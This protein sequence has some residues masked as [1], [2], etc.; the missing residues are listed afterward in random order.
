MEPVAA[1]P[2]QTLSGLADRGFYEAFREGGLL[3]WTNGNSLVHVLTPDR[4]PQRLALLS[5]G[6]KT[7]IVAFDVDAFTKSNRYPHDVDQVIG[8]DEYS[9]LRYLASFCSRNKLGVLPPSTLPSANP[10]ALTLDREGY[11]AVYV[12]RQAYAEAGR[13]ITMFR[14]VTRAGEESVDV[15]IITQLLVPILNRRNGDGSAVFEDFGDIHRKIKDPDEILN[16]D[17]VLSNQ[18]STA[19]PLDVVQDD[20]RFDRPAL[21][22]LKAFL[23]EHESFHDIVFIVR[24]GNGDFHRHKNAK[25]APLVLRNIHEQRVKS[26]SDSIASTQRRATSWFYRQQAEG[27]QQELATLKNKYS[28]LCQ[29]ED[30]LC[31]FILYRADNAKGPDLEPLTWT[32]GSEIPKVNKR[33]DVT[34]NFP[35]FEVPPEYRCPI[36][37]ELME[38]PVTTIDGF[39]YERK[40]IERW[41][42]THETSPCTNLVLASLFLTPNITL[43]QDIDAWVLV[44]D[45]KY[46]YPGHALRV[47]FKSPLIAW[48][49][50][51]SPNMTIRDIYQVAWRM[52]KGRYPA[53]ELQHRDRVLFP[54]EQPAAVTISSNDQQWPRHLRRSF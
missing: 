22:E 24:S 31:A 42:Q 19:A 17:D 32:V 25:K 15:S 46:K 37:T 5:G 16:E 10:P 3:G 8:L 11:L 51:I 1:D 52:T 20:L 14:P 6:T 21:D 33:T 43:K 26:I 39:V 53:F 7:Q 2:V 29:Y 44:T 23:V 36:S 38:D 45:I 30:A 40:N 47:Q 49:L 13:D 28:R 4:K 34:R 50:E 41:F 48:S 27:M 9:D 18:P 54:D 12:G 35:V